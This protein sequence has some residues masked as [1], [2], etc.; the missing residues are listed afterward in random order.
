MDKIRQIFFGRRY[1]QRLNVI[2]NL[3]A[4]IADNINVV[5]EDKIVEEFLFQIGRLQIAKDAA[6]YLL[7]DIEGELQSKLQFEDISAFATKVEVRC[8]NEKDNP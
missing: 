1:K 7:N 8:P 4:E 2:K 5:D 3:F 6:D